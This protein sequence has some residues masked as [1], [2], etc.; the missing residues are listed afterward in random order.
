MTVK[1]ALAGALSLALLPLPDSEFP[2]TITTYHPYIEK[3]SCAGGSGTAFKIADGRWL[4]V[5]HVA[6]IG[7]CYID[8][9]LTTP[10]LIDHEGDFAI[11]DVPGDHRKGGIEVNCEGFKDRVW[12][13]GEGHG[14]GDPFP[15]VVSVRYSAALTF[16]ASM[17][18]GGRGWGVLEGNRFV[19]GMSGGVVLD[20]A[21][22]AVGTVNAY[23]I[24]D[25]ISFSKPLSDTI[26][27]KG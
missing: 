14:R 11:I 13:Y 24:F 8:G 16:I 18:L 9:I 26:I 17:G 27:C 15:Q 6:E 3:V 5:A 4:T 2:P 19:P 7:S 23:G 25:R 20:S 10:L 1:L 21:G 22:R 12:Y